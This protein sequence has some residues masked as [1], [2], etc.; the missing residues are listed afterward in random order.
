M[1]FSGSTERVFWFGFIDDTILFYSRNI[2]EETRQKALERYISVEDALNTLLFF[3]E[4]MIKIIFREMSNI[5]Q[6]LKGKGYLK[7]VEPKDVSGRI[8]YNISLVTNIIN[9]EISCV[10]KESEKINANKLF[11]LKPNF[12]GF[13]INLNY[14]FEKIKIWFFLFKLYN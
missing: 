5:D 11:E 13:G 7:N 1:E 9:A 14:L 4:Y 12:F 2:I 8:N 6:R 10:I 3:L